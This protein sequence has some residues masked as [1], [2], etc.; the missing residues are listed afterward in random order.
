VKLNTETLK[1][2]VT[3]RGWTWSA[4]ADGW[5]IVTPDATATCINTKGPLSPE[6]IPTEGY[7]RLYVSGRIDKVV[8]VLQVLAA[9]GE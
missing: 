3:R 4:D 8:D 9:C 5:C 6:A 1:D 7:P 2:E